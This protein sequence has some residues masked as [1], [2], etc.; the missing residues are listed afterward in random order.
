MREGWD[1]TGRAALRL[2]GLIV[3]TADRELFNVPLTH[4][5]E[6]CAWAVTFPI[7]SWRGDLESRPL[8]A[9]TLD[10]AL[11]EVEALYPL[12]PWW[13]PARGVEAPAYRPGGAL[14]VD[15]APPPGADAVEALLWRL[16]SVSPI[17]VWRV[18]DDVQAL[19]S[20][21]WDE[22]WLSIL[23]APPWRYIGGGM[24]RATWGGDLE[25][26][27][28]FLRQHPAPVRHS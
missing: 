4:L 25:E 26:L 6:R 14:A 9:H 21:G 11:D 20:Q 16:Q 13:W 2:D 15:I 1:L 22:R 17:N 10:A 12:A 24:I 8:Q 7:A 19:I 5:P 28:A 18:G 23:I 3:G 27:R